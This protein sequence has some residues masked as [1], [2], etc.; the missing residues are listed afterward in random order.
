[1]KELIKERQNAIVGKGFVPPVPD[2]PHGRK[3]SLSP[4]KP[5]PDLTTASPVT[6][7]SLETLARELA[8]GVHQTGRRTPKRETLKRVHKRMGE[9]FD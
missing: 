8:D 9:L 3:I 1:M 4:S 2:R 5:E 6:D 7:P